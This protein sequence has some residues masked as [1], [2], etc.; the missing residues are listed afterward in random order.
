MIEEIFLGAP[1]NAKIMIVGVCMQQDQ[2]RPLIA[3]NKELS[4]HFLLGWSMEE[5]TQSLHYISEGRFDVAPL[6]TDRIRLD[7]VPS[8]FEALSTPNSQAKVLVKPWG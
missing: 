4:L 8:T 6:I 7:D 5:F 3:I 2:M 1:Q